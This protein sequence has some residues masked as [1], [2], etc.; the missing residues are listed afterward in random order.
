MNVGAHCLPNIP[1][2]AIFIRAAVSTCKRLSGVLTFRNKEAD[3]KGHQTLILGPSCV[4]PHP[5]FPVI[6]NSIPTTC[7]PVVSK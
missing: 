6:C 4:F 1:T 5:S 2:I 7:D 3:G